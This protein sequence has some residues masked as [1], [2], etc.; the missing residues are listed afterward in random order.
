MTSTSAPPAKHFRLTPTEIRVAEQL[1]AGR[2]NS[3]AAAAL[4]MKP[5][6]FKGH[7]S[8]I[9]EKVQVPTSRPARAHAILLSGQVAPPTTSA[10]RPQLTED[11]QLLLT[12]AAEHST[13]AG[14]ARAAGMSPKTVRRKLAALVTRTGADNLTHLVGLSHYWGYLGA[15]QPAAPSTE[16]C[17]HQSQP[18]E[19]SAS[20]RPHAAGQTCGGAT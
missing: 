18:C 6:T 10:N 19:V 14:I 4:G 1:V 17:A 3:H 9:G 5:E 12:A 2:S 16:H 15:R 13:T 8:K 20:A 7:L 11:D